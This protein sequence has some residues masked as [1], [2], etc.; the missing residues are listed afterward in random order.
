MGNNIFGVVMVSTA[1]EDAK[2]RAENLGMTVNNYLVYDRCR[3]GGLAVQ[4]DAFRGGDV[5]QALAGANVS[6][7]GLFPEESF[8]VRPQDYTWWQGESGNMAGQNWQDMEQGRSWNT[9]GYHNENPG[10]SSLPN[11]GYGYEN[12]SMQ[13]EPEMNRNYS[14]N[15]G[16]RDGRPHGGSTPPAQPSA[17]GSPPAWSDQGWRGES[18]QMEGSHETWQPSQQPAGT[19]GAGGTGGSTVK[20]KKAAETWKSDSWSRGE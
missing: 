3:Q 16:D 7:S 6:L 15:W 1:N 5:G 18:G 13:G 10:Q 9:Q 19:S 11:S 14:E 20:K 8:E 12:W 2:R 4:A 17:G